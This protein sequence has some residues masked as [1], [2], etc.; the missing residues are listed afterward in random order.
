MRSLDR[1]STLPFH[2]DYRASGR[3]RRRVQLCRPRHR[4]GS[5]R[6]KFPRDPCRTNRRDVRHRVARGA[7][8]PVRECAT[9]LNNYRGGSASAIHRGPQSR[10]TTKGRGVRNGFSLSGKI[11]RLR[12]TDSS[13]LIRMRGSDRSRRATRAPVCCPYSRAILERDRNGSEIRD[14]D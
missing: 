8:S 13:R 9:R 4:T 6:D 14:T 1:S 10:P 11:E 3:C 7:A 2:T 5:V 12:Q